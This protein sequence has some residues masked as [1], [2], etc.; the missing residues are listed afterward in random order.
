LVRVLD[1]ARGE[2]GRLGRE[3]GQL[4]GLVERLEDRCERYVS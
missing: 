3:A 4:A 2:A 1:A